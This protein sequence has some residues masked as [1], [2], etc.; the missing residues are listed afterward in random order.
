MRNPAD[1]RIMGTG[2]RRRGLAFALTLALVGI[3]GCTESVPEAP[4]ANG[5]KSPDRSPTI[6]HDHQAQQEERE[7]EAAIENDLGCIRILD[8]A[9]DQ[10]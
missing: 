3:A 4:T 10:A 9:E 8:H 2:P 5:A 7:R 6:A 1:A